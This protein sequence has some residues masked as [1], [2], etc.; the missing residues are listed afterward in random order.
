MKR[1]GILLVMARKLS[2]NVEAARKAFEAKQAVEAAIKAGA[3]EPKKPL[4]L[5]QNIRIPKSWG[6]LPK[7]A[8]WVDEVE[9]VHQNRILVIGH[10]S[11]GGLR[12]DWELASEPAP[13]K[14][15]MAMMQDAAANPQWF[16]RDVL[17]KA[18]RL[19]SEDDPERVKEERQSIEKIRKTLEK[20]ACGGQKGA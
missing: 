17:P 12:L 6:E 18:K 14:G 2:V 8:K 4:P 20:Y 5:V 3:V 16:S 9:W 13:S 11:Q 1:T 10:N 19:D 15:A 7:S